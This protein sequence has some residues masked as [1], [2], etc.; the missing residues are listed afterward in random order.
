MDSKMVMTIVG[1]AAMLLIGVWVVSLVSSAASLPVFNVANESY[2]F[3]ANV[4]AH[5]PDNPTFINITALYN[6]SALTTAIKT[7]TGAGNWSWNASGIYIISN[8]TGA[9]P[10]ITTGTA[11]STY[12]YAY[13]YQVPSSNTTFGSVS[14]VVWSSFQLL[15]V[16]L[17]VVAAFAILGYFGMGRRE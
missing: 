15:A 3:T 13:T 14:G 12:Y 2:N 5:V 11:G 7:G 6:S 17:I 8:G 10:N 1:A 16:V 4:T 9:W